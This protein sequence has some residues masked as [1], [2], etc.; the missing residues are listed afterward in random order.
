MIEQDV[1]VITRH[2]AMPAFTA[3]PS[4]PGRYPAIL[5]YMDAPGIREELRNMARRIARQG[6]FC[7]LPDMY[8]RLGQLRF[9]LSRR[10]DRMS[11]VIG[12]AMRHLD[13]DRVME[14][15][16]GL[17]AFVDAQDRVRPGPVG[18]V[19]Y[20]M[21]G[22]YATVTAARFP[23]RFAGVGSLYGVGLVT[24]DEASPHRLVDRIRG[25][26]Y[27]GFAETDGAAPPETIATLQAA[28]DAAGVRYVLDIHP[29]TRHGYG[30]AAG[31]AYE[32]IA[33]EKSWDRLFDLWDRTLK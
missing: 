11:A 29:G 15:T 25:E 33:A 24:E 32:T 7:V 13:D 8:Y 1:L 5:F 27:Y 31:A 21:S 28:L 17:L 30:F 14:D 10:D 2:G 9:D 4:E 19:G 12:A 20:C 6:Y 3:C 26:M 18:A 16:A 23:H 22:R